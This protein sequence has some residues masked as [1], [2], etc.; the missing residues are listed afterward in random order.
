MIGREPVHSTWYG[1]RHLLATFK[2]PYASQT[3]SVL[4]SCLIVYISC[5]SWPWTTLEWSQRSGIC[6]HVSLYALGRHVLVLWSQHYVSAAIYSQVS[7]N[8][9]AKL[10]WTASL[11]TERN[12]HEI[13]SPIFFPDLWDWCSAVGKC[14]ITLCMSLVFLPKIF[15]TAGRLHFWL[16]MCSSS[17]DLSEYP[18]IGYLKSIQK[19]Q[20]NKIKRNKMK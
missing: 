11:K 10:W 20:M 5:F 15:T 9:A 8:L 4:T 6:P 13:W 2:R 3:G 17:K 14:S 7:T 16:S 18:K 12:G 1:R 19:K